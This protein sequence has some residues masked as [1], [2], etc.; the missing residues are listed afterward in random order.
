MGASAAPRQL[1]D[2]LDFMPPG[3]TFCMSSSGHSGIY[4][5]QLLGSHFSVEK[6]EVW[7]GEEMPRLHKAGFKPKTSFVMS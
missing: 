1:T 2:A 6:T 4:P 3:S 7:E 5:G